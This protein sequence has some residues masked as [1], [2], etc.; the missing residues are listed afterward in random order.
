MDIHER[1]DELAASIEA[2][3]A[4]PMS[5]SCMVNRHEVLAALD[6]IRRLIRDAGREPVERDTLYRHVVREA[7]QPSAWSVGDPIA[8]G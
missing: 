2:A 4:V 3:R 8:I 7:E 5:A 1:L 6:E